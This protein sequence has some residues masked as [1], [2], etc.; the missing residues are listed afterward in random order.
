MAET[1]AAR[2]S[3]L[4]DRGEIDLARGPLFDAAPGPLGAE[5]APRVAGM[6]AGLA[7]G[8]ALGQTPPSTIP[9]RPSDETQL[10]F[11]LLGDALAAGRLR[12]DRVAQA[13]TKH[14]IYG[15]SP[16][17]RDFVR[18]YRA[19]SMPWYRCGAKV[20]DADALARVPALVALHAPS[21]TEALWTD[22]ALAVMMTHDDSAVLAASLGYAALLRDLLAMAEP[23]P[24]GWWPA[25]FVA[26]LEGLEVD[27]HY[28]AR[29]AAFAGFRG[30]LGAFVE[31][32]V[33]DAL[34]RDLPAAE[35]CA[36]FGG[37]AFVL[38][39][40]PCALYV[41]ARHGDDPEAAIAHAAAGATAGDTV[42]A[43]VGAAVGALHG[44]EALPARWREG[45]PG[46][47]TADDD[48]AVWRLIEAARARL[49]GGVS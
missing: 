21:G 18:A 47:T 24:A 15:I 39:A 20:P 27:P 38:E 3:A 5:A 10:A 28:R 17:V 30:T 48:G 7:I 6:L 34:A 40:V 46:R 36:V 16:A 35:A 41:L 22:V 23:P 26:A 33:G 31:R 14:P 37:S 43:I 1:N 19:G 44:V 25:R 32:A 8:D 45:L 49:T 12:P 29:V 4:F 9:D 42:G 11:W 13:W 2:L